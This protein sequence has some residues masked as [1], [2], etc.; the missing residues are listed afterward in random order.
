LAALFGVIG[1]IVG[2]ALLVAWRIR[3]R[4][5]RKRISYAGDPPQATS[6]TAAPVASLPPSEFISAVERAIG[7]E[8]VLLRLRTPSNV[9]KLEAPGRSQ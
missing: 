9:F 3:F 1:G 8:V 4:P 5:E 7:Q 6:V 2:L